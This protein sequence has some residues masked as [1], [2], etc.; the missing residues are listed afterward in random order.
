MVKGDAYRK[1]VKSLWKDR[2]TI[3]SLGYDTDEKSGISE[4]Q[5]VILLCDEPCRIVYKTISAAGEGSAAALKQETLLIIDKNVNIPE[6]SKLT[7]V[8][9]GVTEVY[10]RSGTGAVYSVHKEIPL[11]IFRGWA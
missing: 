9:K 10:N 4:P 3:A 6:G 5:E 11:E 1:A 8:R 7:I 2:C